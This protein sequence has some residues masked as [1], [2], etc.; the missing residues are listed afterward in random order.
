[1]GNI[2]V[3][4]VAKPEKMTSFVT[5]IHEALDM[6]QGSE[7]SELMVRGMEYYT[8]RIL[9][10]VTP[11]SKADAGMMSAALRTI[12]RQLEVDNPGSE[13][14]RR[15]FETSCILPRLRQREVIERANCK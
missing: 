10:A 11:Y 1:M 5:R 8:N 15:I 13:E 12:A 14:V 3:I 4:S 9:S 6:Q 2:T 7:A